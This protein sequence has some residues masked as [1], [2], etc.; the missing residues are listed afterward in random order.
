MK[1]SQEEK[2][3]AVRVLELQRMNTE[4]LRQKWFQLYG[5][6]APELDQRILRQRLAVRIQELVLGGMTERT[7]E[8]L[9]DANRHREHQ[10][11]TLKRRT[12][13]PP[14]GTVLT[15]DYNGESH[16]V[17]VTPEGFEYRGQTYS[18]LSKIANLITGSYW[19]GP[20]FFGLRGDKNG[21]E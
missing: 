14:P 20:L 7:K 5:K 3:L 4:Q 17:V 15:K 18:S 19:S 2:T 8:R 10:Q 6:P 11:K 16:R 9:Q 13:K 12:V 21:K 1:D